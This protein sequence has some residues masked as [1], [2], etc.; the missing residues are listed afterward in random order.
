VSTVPSVG[1]YVSGSYRFSDWFAAELYYSVLYPDDND[2]D[3]ARFT[4]AGQDDFLAWQK[5]ISLTGRF[6]L[7][8]N[9]IF[10]A[11]VTLSNGLAGGFSSDYPSGGALS[12]DWILYQCKLTFVF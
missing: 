2:R 5:D 12:E 3:G 6:D 1:W 9:W 8:E 7:T 11:G 10:K 4:A